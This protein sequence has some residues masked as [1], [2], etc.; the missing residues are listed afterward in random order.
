VNV[1]LGMLVTWSD[2][3]FSEYQLFDYLAAVEVKCDAFNL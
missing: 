3:A 1:L 2:K